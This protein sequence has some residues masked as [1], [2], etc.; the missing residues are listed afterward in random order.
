MSRKTLP[1]KASWSRDGLTRRWLGTLSTGGTS[2]WSNSSRTKCGGRTSCWPTTTW[3]VPSTSRA[4]TRSWCACMQPAP[5]TPT[6]WRS[7]SSGVRRLAS[8]CTMTSTWTRTL[9]TRKWSRSGSTRGWV[10]SSEARSSWSS[11]PRPVHS[12]R[13]MSQIRHSRTTGTKYWLHGWMP[14][15]KSGTGW[16]SSRLSSSLQ[17]T[18][19]IINSF[20]SYSS[21]LSFCS[22]WI[23]SIYCSVAKSPN[24]EAHFNC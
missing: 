2:T 6:D 4:R 8:R 13:R 22:F 17:S 3:P 11:C 7:T 1:W 24:W 20:P 12:S 10:C 14:S 23:W 15:G 5:R 9:S 16:I 21:P 19:V 18:G